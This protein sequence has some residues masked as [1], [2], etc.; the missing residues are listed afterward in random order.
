VTP[1]SGSMA[2]LRTWVSAGRDVAGCDE[3]PQCAKTCEDTFG[4]DPIYE[5]I[6]TCAKDNCVQVCKF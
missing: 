6:R 5:S 2:L 3:T 4:A 1:Y